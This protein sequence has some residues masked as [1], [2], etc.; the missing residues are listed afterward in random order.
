MNSL[1]VIIPCLKRPDWL[2]KTLTSVL[3]QTTREMEII[4]VFQSE[5]DDQELKK[6]CVSEGVIYIYSPIFSTPR[7]RNIG[8]D[9]ASGDICVFFDDDVELQPGCLEAHLNAYAEGVV[10]VSGR[11]ITLREYGEDKVKQKGINIGRVNSLAKV[12]G[13]QEYNSLTFQRG[14]ITP[15]GCNMSLRRSTIIR[16]GHYDETYIGN[17]MRE[18][19]DLAVRALEYGDFVFVPEACVKHFLA[20]TGGTRALPASKWFENYFYNEGYFIAKFTKRYLRPIAY[21]RLTRY[22]L[23]YYRSFG[24]SWSS[25]IMPFQQLK[26]AAGMLKI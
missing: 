24:R 16:A 8:V 23:K 14:Q 4:V 19:T 11:V 22:L 3:G 1:S 6:W 12:C 9:R 18:E 21:F 26:K 13:D 7:S 17:A 20:K 15:L 10:G 25:I 2:K 5:E